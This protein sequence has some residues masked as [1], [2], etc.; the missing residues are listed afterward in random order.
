MFDILK[1][2]IYIS[3]S[4]KVEEFIWIIKSFET[5][6]GSVSQNLQG[7]GKQRGSEEDEWKKGE[8]SFLFLY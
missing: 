2:K 1:G 7:G 8:I 3:Y 4:K 6:F 5:E